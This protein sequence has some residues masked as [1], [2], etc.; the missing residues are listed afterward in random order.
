[1]P[2]GF[3]FGL[4]TQPLGV[5]QHYATALVR[6]QEIAGVHLTDRTWGRGDGD[7]PELL[8]SLDNCP[9]I[10]W[11]QPFYLIQEKWYSHVLFVQKALQNQE[12]KQHLDRDG[13]AI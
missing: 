5:R 9:L 2:Y 6:F 11:I 1:M 13:R 8:G 12:I 4:E 7:K 3:R 10:G